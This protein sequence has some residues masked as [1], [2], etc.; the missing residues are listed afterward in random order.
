MFHD[1]PFNA[2]PPEMITSSPGYAWNV[3]KESEGDRFNVDAPSAA[4]PKKKEPLRRTITAASAV[5]KVVFEERVDR[6][7]D[8]ARAMDGKGFASE[9]SASRAAEDEIVASAKIIVDASDEVG[10]AKGNTLKPLFSLTRG[11]S[12]EEGATLQFTASWAPFRASA[13]S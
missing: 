4:E 7:N 11:E 2:V 5:D 3:M 9:P 12:K 10:R 1:S 8:R 6:T 13:S